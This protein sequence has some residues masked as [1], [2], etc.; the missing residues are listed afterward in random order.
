MFLRDGRAVTK[1]Y[2]L[3]SKWDLDE[4]LHSAQFLSSPFKQS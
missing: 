2:F 3:G 4:D 1:L